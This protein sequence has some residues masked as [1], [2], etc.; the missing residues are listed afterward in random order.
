MQKLDSFLKESQRFTPPSLRKYSSVCISLL[1]GSGSRTNG[2]LNLQVAVNRVVLEPLTL[3]DGFHLPVGTRSSMSCAAILH[4][5]TVTFQP[6]IFDGFR[7]YKERQKPGEQ[8]RHQ[9]ATTDGN[10][11]H[12]GHGK[13]ACP[14]RFFA[15]NEIK[16]IL[17]TIILK[18]DMRFPG[19]Q[20]RPRNM[21]AHEYIFPDPDGLVLLKERESVDGNWRSW[22]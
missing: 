13:Y 12:F 11:L 2:S 10:N 1:Q 3:S 22:L 21:S 7:Y 8:N 17:A 18:Y 20:S 4:D 19:G 15:S 16:L 9:F 5:P 14:G 6:E